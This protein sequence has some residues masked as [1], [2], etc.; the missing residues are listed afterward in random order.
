MDANQSGFS[1]LFLA[2]DWTL[3]GLNSGCA[4]GAA[5]SGARCAQAVAGTLVPLAG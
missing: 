1:N 3:N 4:E 5:I 2:G